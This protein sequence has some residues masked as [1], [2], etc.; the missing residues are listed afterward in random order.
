[1]RL[2]LLAPIG[3]LV[4]CAKA[5]KPPVADTTA[6]VAPAPPPPPPPVDLASLAG[7]W[8]LNTMPEG[9]DT[10]ISSD[11]VITATTEGWTMK[12]PGRKAE[13]VRVR[14]DAD[15][16]MTETGPFASVLRKGAK[17]TTNAV[18]HVQAGKLVGTMVAHYQ[19]G[20]ADSVMRG[21]QEATRK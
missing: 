7:N 5:D 10:V 20:G 3:L 11:L 13:P 14:V 9:R 8:T 4:A 1:M 15:S 18:Y 16:I 6:A 12:L 2:S 19:G 17:V 21:R